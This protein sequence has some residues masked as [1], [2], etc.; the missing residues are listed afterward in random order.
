M[1]NLLPDNKKLEINAARTNIILVDYILILFLGVAFLCLISAIVYSTLMSTKESAENVI[2]DNKAASSSYDSIRTEAASLR[3]ELTYAKTLLDQEVL[4]TK[5]ITNIAKVMPS[6]T[7]LGALSLGS[8]TFGAPTTLQVYAKTTED[9]LKLKSNF[10][11]SPFFSDV[12]FQSLTSSTQN[13]TA[14]YPIAATLSVVINK[15][16]AK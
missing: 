10:Q 15:S 1:I 11:Q 12:T 6:G 8:T 7:V 16:A 13:N 5:V 9:A 4:Y 3:S 2:A 14:G